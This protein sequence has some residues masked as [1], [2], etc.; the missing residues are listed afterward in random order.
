MFIVINI[1]VLWLLLQAGKMKGTDKMGL[2][3]MLRIFCMSHKQ[4]DSFGHAY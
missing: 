4:K 3:F 1:I 2:S